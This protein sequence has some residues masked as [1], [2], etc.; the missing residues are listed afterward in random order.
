MSWERKE[1]V[2]AGFSIK[3]N[4]AISSKSSKVSLHQ[5]AAEYTFFSSS[6]GAFSK[7]DH[8]LDHETHFNK[9]KRVEII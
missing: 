3:A 5:T 7:I 4:A 2:K 8:I 1:N 9:F 6:Y